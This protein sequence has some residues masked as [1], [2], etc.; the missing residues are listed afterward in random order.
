M[1][2]TVPIAM[3]PRTGE[4]SLLQMDGDLT[5]EEMK[6]VFEMASKACKE[7]FKLQIKALKDKYKG[8]ATQ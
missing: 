1:P 7:I 6:K 3:T 8:E 4:I 2:F 5:E